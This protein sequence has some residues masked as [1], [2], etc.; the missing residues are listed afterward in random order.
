LNDPSAAGANASKDIHY[1]LLLR[2]PI[3][4]SVNVPLRTLSTLPSSFRDRRKWFIM[5]HQNEPVAGP[6]SPNPIRAVEKCV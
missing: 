5:S 3:E 6:K 1:S 4:L 2:K